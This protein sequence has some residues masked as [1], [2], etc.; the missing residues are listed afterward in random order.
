LR[1]FVRKYS[2]F[3]FVQRSF[4]RYRSSRLVTY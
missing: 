3:F 2:I 4:R 1:I